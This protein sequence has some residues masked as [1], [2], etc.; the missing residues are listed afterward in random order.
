MKDPRI[1]K[2][3]DVLVN[4][5]C[6]VQPG[7]FVM[8]DFKGRDT[9]PLAAACCEKVALA[10]GVPIWLYQG[11]DI[12][13]SFYKNASEAQYQKFGQLHT[14]IMDKMDCYIGVR[15]SDNPFDLADLTEERQTFTKKHVW[16]PVH[17]ETRIKKRWVVL[18][19]PTPSMSL[20]A[21]MATEAFEDFYFDVCTLDYSK[22]A[23]AMEPLKA[24]ME[25]TDKVHIKGPG[26][27]LSFSI[28]GMGAIPCAGECN[29]PD[30]EIFTA[31]IRD[32]VNGTVYYN[33]PSMYN[34][35]R[36]AGVRFRFEN[37]KIV[38]ATCDNNTEA[39]N[40]LLDSDEGARYI[41]EFAIGIN[42]YINKP[43]LDILF[44]EKINGSFHFT[45]GNAYDEMD[46]GNRSSVHW[47]LVS[48]QREDWGGGEMCFDD[49]LIR[50]D[51]IF[52]HP[53]L[54]EILAVENLKND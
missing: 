33:A 44:D 52:V 34:G 5:S 17:I 47:D 30:G 10:G 48:I 24:L 14:D 37:G 27:D 23:A 46:N 41:G 26:T 20:Q 3:A 2:L 53:D 22:M 39:L 42:P 4:Y 35:Q 11:E 40:A 28:K 43:M 45:P 36:Y 31:P 1:H 8:I 29:I 25:K 38:E 16:V 21:E 6:K 54:K 18:R 49:V 13:R 50:K 19:Y 12:S 7:E 9:F 15:G 51:G 32:S